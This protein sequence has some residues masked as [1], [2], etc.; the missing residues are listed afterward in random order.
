MTAVVIWVEASA[1]AP[2]R[3]GPPNGWYDDILIL[4]WI[5]FQAADMIVRVVVADS[6]CVVVITVVVG[7][8][9][10]HF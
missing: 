7:Q 8:G 2:D 9:D 6:Q 4:V 5:F 1:C 10:D 3:R